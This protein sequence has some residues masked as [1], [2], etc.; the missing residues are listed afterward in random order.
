MRTPKF[1]ALIQLALLVLVAPALAQAPP[2]YINRGQPTIDGERAPAG[3]EQLTLSTGSATALAAI[4]SKT[5]NVPPLSVTL[6][7]IIVS[8]N[9]VRFRDDG[10][11]PTASVGMPIAAGG[12]WIYTGN[13]ANLRF[14]RQSATNA[15][16]DVMYYY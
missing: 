9:D 6:T 13:P 15:V 3:Y 10:T 16:L 7:I 12:S 2:V 5:S 11:N 8:S 14:I 1:L 4:P